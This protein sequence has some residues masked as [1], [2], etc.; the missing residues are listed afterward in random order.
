[1]TDDAESVFL[2][3]CLSLRRAENTSHRGGCV[4]SPHDD[5]EGAFD[6]GST[7]GPD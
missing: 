2:P 3:I 5:P 7:S 1:M 6:G 4:F